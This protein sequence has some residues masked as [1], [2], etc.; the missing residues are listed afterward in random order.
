MPA[1]GIS[2]MLRMYVTDFRAGVHNPAPNVRTVRERPATAVLDADG[3]LGV[4]VGPM[5]MRL[6]VEKAKATG[7][8]SVSVINAGHLGGAGYH[9]MVAAEAGCIGQCF[10]A[11]GG[12]LALPTFGAEPRFGTHPIAWAAPAGE[13]PPFLFDV[14]TTQIAGN[15]IRLAAR[16]GN[17]LASDWIAEPLG[18]PNAGAVIREEVDPPADFLMPPLGGTRENGSHKGYGLQCVVDL[19]CNSMGGV[20]AGCLTGGGGILMVAYDIDA[21]VDMTDYT[22]WADQFLQALRTCPP[23][24]GHEVRR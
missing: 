9:A 24:P 21:F 6:A 10:A 2:N 20:G 4:H 14:A 8:G 17:R 7:M 18:S 19:L 3:G 22:A 16:M 1:D 5:A 13:E 12:K 15:K 23:A 11:P